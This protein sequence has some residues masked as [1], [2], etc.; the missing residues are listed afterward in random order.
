MVLGISGTQALVWQ[1]QPFDFLKLSVNSLWAAGESKQLFLR[2][3]TAVI[4]RDAYNMPYLT[5]CPEDLQR[6]RRWLGH[7]K[8]KLKSHGLLDLVGKTPR[9][10]GCP[11][12][13]A[14]PPFHH[15]DSAESV[16]QWKSRVHELH[17]SGHV[18]MGWFLQHYEREI[19][20]AACL[21][22]ASFLRLPERPFS[23]MTPAIKPLVPEVL[24]TEPQILEAL[25]RPPAKNRLLH[26]RSK[27][28][29]PLQVAVLS[30]EF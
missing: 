7:Y 13:F 16:T 20:A 17:D 29:K 28:W 3:L 23:C 24:S 26:V 1:P 5:R 14:P 21:A 9:M 25:S 10:K 30:R 12:T 19:G 11:P 22:I 27:F 2:Y 4:L 15:L 18:S 6:Q 8:E